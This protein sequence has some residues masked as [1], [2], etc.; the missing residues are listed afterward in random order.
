MNYALNEYQITCP[1]CWEVYS[2]VLE[3]EA[4]TVELIEDCQICC[5]PIQLR[6]ETAFDEEVILHAERAM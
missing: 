2:L 5:H 3:T 4:S 6:M 1:Y